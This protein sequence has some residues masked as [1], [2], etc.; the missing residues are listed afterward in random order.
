[1]MPRLQRT[2]RTATT[3]LAFTGIAFSQTPA[4]QS[5]TAQPSPSSVQ[6]QPLPASMNWN[7]M[8]DEMQQLPE[9][10]RNLQSQAAVLPLATSVNPNFGGF[11]VAPFYPAHKSG[12][13][14]RELSSVEADFNQ[15]GCKD[16]VSFQVISLTLMAG[17]CKGGFKNVN[18][19]A[20]AMNVFHPVVADI[21]HDGYPDIV[22]MTLPSGYAG[23]VVAIINQ[24]NGT[25]APAVVISKKASVYSGLQGF[26]LYDVNGDGNLD[27]IITGTG[28]QDSMTNSNVVFEVVFGNHDGTFNT[29]TEVETVGTLPY[30]PT[31]A[32]DGGTTVRVIG[33]QLYFYGLF[34]QS[35]RVNGVSFGSELLY[36]WTVSSNGKVDVV[37]PQIT[38]LPVFSSAPN[39]YIYFADLNGDGTPD[40][41]LLNGDGMLYTAIGA[42]DGS[43]GTLQMALPVAAG[44][45]AST[46]SFRDVD[47]DGKVDAIIAGG[48]LV[49]MWPGVGDGTFI[50]PKLTNFAGY[51]MNANAGLVFPVSN[52]QIDDFDGDGVADVAFFDTIKR[53]LCFYKGKA[54]G[55]FVGAPA[56]VN[57]SGDFQTNILA[58]LGTPD[59]NGDGYKDVIVNTPY[60]ILSGLNDGKGNFTYRTLS[61][62]QPITSISSNAVDFNKDGKDDVVFLAADANG[63][64]HLYIGLSD[65]DGTITAI[66]QTLPYKATASPGL[67]IGDI[68]GDGAPDL[69]LALNN[70]AAASYGVWPMV[71]DGSGHLTAGTYV[72]AGVL[73]YGVALVDTN[74]D[75]KADL[76]LSYG[77]YAKTTT[78]V[79]LSK[80]NGSFA[81]SSWTIQNTLPASSILAQDV[82][83][84]GVPDAVLSITNGNSEGL[85]L[86]TGNGDGTFS[87]GTSILQ[88]IIPAA[89]GAADLNGD[90]VPDIFVSNTETT[91]TD[92]SDSVLGVVVLLGAGN[93]TFAAPRSYAIYGASAPI[94]PVDLLHN[95]SPSL[96]A[97]AGS[98][99][100]TVLLNNGASSI[101]LSSQA[102]SIS[103][104]NTT[105]ITVTVS[106]YYRDQAMPTGTV[107]LYVDKS[108]VATSGLASNGTATF[109]LSSLTAGSHTISATYGGDTNYN[110]NSNSSTVTLT[111]TKSTPAFTLSSSASTLSMSMGTQ[112]TAS[113][114]LSANNAFS[115]P[116]NLTCL[117]AP[118]GTMCGFS[119]SNVT[120]APGQSVTST[121]TLSAATTALAHP[122]ST[123]V[124]PIASGIALCG[125]LVLTPMVRRRKRL[126]TPLLVLMATVAGLGLSG[127]SSNDKPK[128][129][130]GTYAVTVSANPADS[131]V[132]S[133]SVVVMVTVSK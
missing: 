44:N 109:T 5:A 51:A 17:D 49:G 82:T 80:G 9:A 47:G 30:K 53:A 92:A 55:T 98:N 128:L 62:L 84:D 124:G 42:P 52:H 26:N 13:A 3:L 87:S 27:A 32:F 72:N 20:T 48:M 59:L 57:T 75:G 7:P 122:E 36:R 99:G 50:A 64:P 74:K 95:G 67:A 125:L 6:S 24:K 91:L 73:L 12:D 21:N 93:G 28:T 45:N 10:D 88:G 31:F 118:S 78:A 14:T 41:T 100:T 16:I 103:L 34:L 54:D 68:N 58:I 70:S 63:Y 114:T 66:P 85:M 60:G 129:S 15:D 90:S 33:G 101:S 25:F 29:S 133:Q 46:I 123:P 105:I 116:V 18:S 102:S 76:L 107:S 120:L 1:M 97:A 39:K 115:G 106:P 121:L 40:F 110:V 4:Q 11:R 104:G 117:G 86:Y 111:V 56:L 38:Q 83:G 71:N 127:C 77:A 132:A 61:P 37:N 81:P 131:S 23:T 126:L 19:Q 119:Q 112:A 8:L 130:P 113:M 2:L 22:A 96:L 35:E 69:V 108:A 65:G 43:L 89:V 79:Y 94:L